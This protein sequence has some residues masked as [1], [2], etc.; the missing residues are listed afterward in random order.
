M[1]SYSFSSPFYLNGL[2]VPFKTRSHLAFEIPLRKSKLGQ[3][4]I[5]FTGL[6]I[7]NKLGN[8][9]KTLKAAT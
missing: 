4:S 5:L 6:S 8:D 3:K 9:L 2:F 1:Q 7:W